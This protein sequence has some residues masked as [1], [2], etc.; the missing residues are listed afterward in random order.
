MRIFR[1]AAAPVNPVDPATF[2]GSATVQRLAEDDTAVPVGVY[3]VRF[4]DGAR[5]NWHSHSGPQWLFIVEGRI[6][7]QRQGEPALDVA[8][9]DAV[10]FAPGEKHWHGAVPGASGTHIAVNVDVKTT[11]ME[12]VSEDEYAGAGG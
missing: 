8:S 2:V 3:R 4:A 6:R 10:V 1:S 7:V 11:W 5:T 12:P 9:G